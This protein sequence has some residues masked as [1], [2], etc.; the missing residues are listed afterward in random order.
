MSD[1]SLNDPLARAAADL[2]RSAERISHGEN[3]VDRVAE[4]VADAVD[5]AEGERSA[6]HGDAAIVPAA[7]A[8]EA[9]TPGRAC[10]DQMPDEEVL[11]DLADL[12]KVFADTTRIKILYALMV[13]DLNVSDLAEAV[14]GVSQSAVSHQ[15]R[16][17]KQAHLVRFRREGKQVIYALSDDHVYTMLSQG[18]SHICE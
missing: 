7:D 14:G 15:L 16:I 2:V 1:D 3:P 17:L 10:C 12:F 4:G 18:L 9:R 8:R 13:E 5:A 6:A 11:Y